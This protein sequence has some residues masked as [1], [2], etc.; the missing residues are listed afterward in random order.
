VP[1][2]AELAPFLEAVE[3]STTN[4]Q[5]EEIAASIRTP[6]LLRLFI[7]PGCPYCP[8]VVGQVAG[9]ARAADTVDLSVID[10][11]LFEELARA[12]GI[13]STPTLVAEGG[14]RW[15]G[16]LDLAELGGFLASRDPAAIGARALENMLKA[17]DAAR[18]ARL[19]VTAKQI[20]PALF[21]LLGH[22]QWSVRLGA[23]V[24]V[25]EIAAAAPALA[26]AIVEPLWER[27]ETLDPQARGDVLY[28]FGEAGNETAADKLRMV[29]R[30]SHE[31]EVKAAARE[32][33]QSLEAR[34]G[35]PSKG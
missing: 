10:G 17:G 32:A 27:F 25:E 3:P 7:A 31:D 4:G 33:L 18:A 29:L 8:R 26:A 14:W 12:E 6:A 15:T 24:V 16:A 5:L 11:L 30:G 19:M 20:F 22:P 2:G 35:Q 13:Q 28:L 23:M 34:H 1:N 9:L 21:D